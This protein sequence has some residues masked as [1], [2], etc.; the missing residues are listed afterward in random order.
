MRKRIL[1]PSPPQ[2]WVQKLVCTEPSFPSTQRQLCVSIRATINDLRVIILN[3]FLRWLL[4][5]YSGFS[6]GCLSKQTQ[7]WHVWVAHFQW[8]HLVCEVPKVT[9]GQTKERSWTGGSRPRFN[10]REFNQA[11]HSSKFPWLRCGHKHSRLF[12]PRRLTVW[13]LRRLYR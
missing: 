2:S 11:P 8:R 12:F 1:F 3:G 6:R 4:V 9:R 5:D 10:M 7:S 13:K